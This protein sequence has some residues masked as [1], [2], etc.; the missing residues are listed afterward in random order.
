MEKSSLSELVM[1]NRSCRRFDQ[2]APV[3]QKSLEEF[4][5]LARCSAS[6]ANLQP[7]KYICSTDDGKNR[8]IFAC[9]GWAA[10]FTKWKGACEG[11]Q[12]AAYIIILGD[13]SITENFRC[14]HGIAAQSILLGAREKGYAGCMLAAINHKQLRRVIGIQEHLEILLVIA[15]GKP[16]ETIIIET[17]NPGEDHRYWR[18]DEGVHHVP[19]RGMDE[20]LLKAF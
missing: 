13:K 2:A 5:D 1:A 4:I 16:A 14:D 8:E 9:L 10:Y 19:K 6:A 20:I 7:L 15:L 11:E 18:D 17:L 3:D 12:P